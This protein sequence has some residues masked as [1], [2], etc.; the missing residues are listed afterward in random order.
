[1][2]ESRNTEPGYEQFMELFEKYKSPIYA[3]VQRTTGDQYVAEEITQEVFIKLWKRRDRFSEI[4]NTDHYIYRMAHNACMNWFKKLALD[5]KLAREVKERMK[6]ES[7]DVEDHIAQQEAM[8]LLQ[9]ALDTLSPQRRKVFE[10][11]R[12]EGMRLQE[13]AEQ[14]GLSFHTV[15]HHLVAALSQIREYFLTHGKDKALLLLIFVLIS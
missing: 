10:L 7:N 15:N 8:A 1:M 2:T 4:E 11:S 12:K 14:M 13:I 3:Y 9:K 6:M 5:A